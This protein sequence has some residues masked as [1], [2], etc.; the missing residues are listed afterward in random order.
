[1]IKKVIEGDLSKGHVENCPY[2]FIFIN[3]GLD[4]VPE[5]LFDQLVDGGKIIAII[6]KEARP[7]PVVVGG[8][9]EEVREVM[10]K[11][12][13]QMAFLKLS[14]FEGSIEVVFFPRTYRQYR[15]LITRDRC[16]AIK[17]LVSNRNDEVSIVA[18]AAKEL[19]TT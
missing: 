12:N 2:N 17:G 5:E 8:L 7:R 6:K 19:S 10:T 9:I 14:D 3:G 4:S 16:V 1:M 18:E 15:E 13:D 11:T